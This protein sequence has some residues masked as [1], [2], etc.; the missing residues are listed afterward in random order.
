MSTPEIE[1][2]YLKSL[3]TALSQ[4]EQ[5][6]LDKALADGG[7]LLNDLQHYQQ[8][9]N[10][11]RSTE[12]KTFG[13]YFATRLMYKIQNTGVVI[14]REIFSFFR[15]FQLAAVGIVIALIALNIFYSEGN[16]L[17]AIGLE[18]TTPTTSESDIVSFDYSELL[19]ENL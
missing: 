6:A 8:I 13:P 11:L 1:K 14:D 15:K 17:S 4:K 2:L 5:E 12:S 7:Q 3:D 9:R 19:N 18:S 16:L 10:V